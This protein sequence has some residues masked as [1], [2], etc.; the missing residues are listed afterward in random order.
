MANII[1]DKR[2]KQDKHK[3]ITSQIRRSLRVDWIE[4]WEWT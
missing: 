1:I 4:F 3:I 2:S